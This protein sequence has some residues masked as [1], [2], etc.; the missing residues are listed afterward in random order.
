MDDLGLVKPV[1][2]LG[3]GIVVTVADTTDEK[4]YPRFGS[5]NRNQTG[6][7][8]PVMAQIIPC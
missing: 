4:F 5:L 1:D 3:G 7:G 2:G 6:C 8:F